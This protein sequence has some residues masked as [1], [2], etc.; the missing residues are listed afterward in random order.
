MKVE[1]GN[2]KKGIRVTVVVLSFAVVGIAGFS[3]RCL[4]ITR[5]N[6][7]MAYEKQMIPGIVCW[8][9]SLTYGSG[10]N[11]TSYPSV[12]EEC[13]RN[14]RMYIP[15]VNMGIGGENTVTIAGRAGAVPFRLK[16]FTIPTESI[17][18][19]IFFQEDEGKSI[20][21]SYTQLKLPTNSKV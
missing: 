1:I 2:L 20:P 16:E 8:G 18:V 10:G 3:I 4:Y 9:D 12:L 6:L 15:V 17:P 5:E 14:E 11:G 21:D 13:L 19:E 7:L